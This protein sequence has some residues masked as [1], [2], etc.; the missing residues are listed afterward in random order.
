MQ[1]VCMKGKM[2]IE[3]AALLVILGASLPLSTYAVGPYMENERPPGPRVEGPVPDLVPPTAV[4]PAPTPRQAVVSGEVLRIEGEFYVVKESTGN[5]VSLQV[6]NDT[7]M[8][9]IPKVGDK[10]EAEVTPQF[11]A[12]TIKP[13]PR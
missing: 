2:L 9:T 6:D 3:V 13:A 8:N 11:H 5:E 12:K 10:I 4:R 1:E 7:R